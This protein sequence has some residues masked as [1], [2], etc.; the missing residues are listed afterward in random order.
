M[1]WKTNIDFKRSV[2][3]AK[4]LADLRGGPRE[5]STPSLLF[6][7]ASFTMASVK[8]LIW[9]RIS[10]ILIRIPF[11]PA[12]P[13]FYSYTFFFISDFQLFRPEHH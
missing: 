4:Q 11:L 13:L 7:T 1:F 5:L 6:S 12:G 10:H 8:L 9:Y 3:K 2:P